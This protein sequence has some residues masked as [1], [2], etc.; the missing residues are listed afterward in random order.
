MILGRWIV[1]VAWKT[2]LA[3]NGWSAARLLVLLRLVASDWWREVAR[4]SPISFTL[5]S[6]DAGGW[7][8]RAEMKTLEERPNPADSFG[9]QNHVKSALGIHPGPVDVGL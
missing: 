3:R 1:A 5:A 4:P 7:L 2:Q 9:D 6:L 8:Q